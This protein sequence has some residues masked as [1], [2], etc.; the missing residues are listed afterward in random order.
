MATSQSPT[1]TPTSA[2]AR[3]LG[4]FLPYLLGRRLRA[5][6][7][8]AG[9]GARALNGLLLLLTLGYGA[10][11]GFLLRAAP[12][13]P[14]TADLVSGLFTGLN[15]TLL[16]SALF[17]DFLPTLRPV[18]RPLPEHLPVSARLNLLTAFLLD[19]LTLRR[20]MLLVPLLVGGLLAPAQAARPALAGL[21]LLAGAVLSF[22]LR[23]LVALGRWRGPWLAAPLTGL[24]GL[25]WWLTHPALPHAAALGLAA[26]ALP[27]ALGAA[28]LRWLGPLFSA[29]YMPAAAGGAETGTGLLARLSPEAK[30]YVRRVRLPLLMGLAS[31]VIFFALCAFA[32]T[33]FVASASGEG[34]LHVFYLF[35]MPIVVFTYA[36]NNFFGHLGAIPANELQ[37]L[38]LTRRLLWLYARL[39]GPTVLLDCLLTTGLTLALLPRAQ[40]P[41]LGLLPL[42]ALAFSSIGLWSSLYQAKPVI[43]AVD[44][45]NMRNNVSVLASFGTIVL[46]S[47]LYYLPWWSVRAALALVISAS[48][49]WPVRA[50]LRNDGPLRRRLWRTVV[51]EQ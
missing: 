17:T 20:L 42:A 30:V 15:A 40:W 6:V 2:A 27:W 1:L 49:Y 43:K 47:A 16:L 21:V 9:G 45:T 31:K 10:G 34:S 22:Q 32:P 14:K 26:V 38:G 36:N 41:L 48:A 50:V 25:G 39:V 44:F 23:L 37:R 33:R 24:A 5:V 13:E 11:L 8:P 28:L 19:L 29:R 51:N 12:A 7:W 18:V 3:P 46:G 35:F 4:H